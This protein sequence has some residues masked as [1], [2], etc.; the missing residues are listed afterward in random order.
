VSNALAAATAA[1]ELGIGPSTIAA[2]LDAAGPVP[3]RFELVDAG[4]PFRVVVD[5]SHKPDGLARVLESARE[6]AAGD[7]RVLVVFGCGGDRDRTKRPHMGAVAVELADVVVV[8][9]D[10][11]RHEDPEAI[12]AEIV[13]GIADPA[14]RQDEGALVVEA[15]RRAA[16][17]TALDRARPGDVVVVAGKGHETTQT[18]GDRA[19]PFD[20]REVARELLD[21]LRTRT[22]QEPAW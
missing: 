10:N 16:I 21:D 2:G 5:Y 12:I 8:T 1:A 17:A 9:S 18:I 13:A 11:P 6:V 3:G 22:G 4:Q 7:G 20:D 19:L 15:D 14:G